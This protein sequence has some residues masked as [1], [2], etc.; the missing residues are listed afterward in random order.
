MGFAASGRPIFNKP[1]PIAVVQDV[2]VQLPGVKAKT[3]DR[4]HELFLLV[5]QV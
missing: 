2:L 3:S 1:R 4:F 5:G